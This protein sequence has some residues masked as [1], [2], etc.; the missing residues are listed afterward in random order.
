[1]LA[2]G[3]G[4]RLAPLTRYRPKPL[5]PVGTK[6]LIDHALDRVT[7][8][9]GAT[10]VNLHHLGD[11]LDDHLAP[12]V[13]RSWER[14]D[15]LG[16]AG[17]LGALRGWLDGRHVVLTNGDAWFSDELD[18]D[19]MITGWDRE[20]TRLLTVRSPGRGDFGD[21]MYCGVALIPWST[22]VELEAVPSGLYEVSW[23]QERE[24]GRLDLVETGADFVDCGTPGDYLAANLAHSGGRSVIDP[25]AQVGPG[26]S[27]RRSVVWD[28]AA[29]EAGEVLDRAVR[30]VEVTV[31][32][33]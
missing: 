9:T 28:G 24:A 22:V 32:I 25:T 7:P 31:L 5:C 17:A 27:V 4:S 30:T 19:E 23:R 33:R 18:L 16:T 11:Q 20:R 1:M 12:Q 8:L 29:V 21:L 26:A 13:H 10:A 15:A 6:P 2:A 14:P 3:T